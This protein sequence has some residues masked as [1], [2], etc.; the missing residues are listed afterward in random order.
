MPKFDFECWKRS[1]SQESR[2]GSGPFGLTVQ[3]APDKPSLFVNS[4][5]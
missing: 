4:A 5:V 2:L 1:G 3:T